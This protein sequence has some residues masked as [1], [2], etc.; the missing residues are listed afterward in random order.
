VEEKKCGAGAGWDDVRGELK[1]IGQVQARFLKLLPV[2]DGLKFCGCECRQKISIC[3][4][5]YCRNT[6]AL[7]NY[8]LASDAEIMSAL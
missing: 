4:G 1:S 8:A 3:V 5:L 2:W 6:A 7:K